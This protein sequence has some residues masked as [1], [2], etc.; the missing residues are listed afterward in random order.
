MKMKKSY[1][2]RIYGVLFLLLFGTAC[3]LDGDEECLPCKKVREVGVQVAGTLPA[4]ELATPLY[5]FLRPAGTQEEYRFDRSYE[6]LADGATLKLPLSEM[7]TSDYRFLM[8]AQ[9]D[10]AA[11]LTLRT[12]EG[13]PFVP[14][15]A[16]SGLRIESGTGAATL[17]GYCGFTE[18]SGEEILLEGKLQLK[19]TRIAGQVLFDFFRIGSSL[20]DPEGVQ[21]AAVTSVIDRVSGIEIEYANPTTALRFDADDRLVPAAYGSEPLRQVIAPEAV[22]FRVALPQADKGLMQYDAA[23]RGSLRIGG[24]ALL[25]SDGKLR[26]K[27][28]FTYYDTTPSC[29]NAHEGDHGASCYAQQLLTLNLPALSSAAGLPVAAD[30]FTVNRT[31]LRCDR[32]IDVP[33]SGGIESDF[34][35]L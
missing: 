33:A 25:P 17:D 19:L 11:W 13:G 21:S 18:M 10:G 23:L 26:I 15:T 5:V 2:Y 30:C 24:A 20:S 3:A 35:W 9:P 14:G 12:A 4:Q 7:K 29:G 16:W 32:V 22:D 6:T 34:G 1:I 31:G 27:I 8:L 28:L